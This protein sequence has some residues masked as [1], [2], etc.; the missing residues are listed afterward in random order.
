MN[1]RDAGSD[2]SAKIMHSAAQA[3]ANRPCATSAIRRGE[4]SRACRWCASAR[5]R[6]SRRP[7]APAAMQRRVD[8]AG[9]AEQPPAV[10]AL[11]DR[12]LETRAG[13]GNMKRARARTGRLPA[14]RG[15]RCGGRGRRRRA[16]RARS[17]PRRGRRGATMR[18]DAR[19]CARGSS[20][21]SREIG[22]EQAVA[23]QHDERLAASSGS[24]RLMPPPVSR[25]GSSGE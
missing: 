2:T 8:V 9:D 13:R 25:I 4:R 16:R 22:L 14:R 24:A 18:R 3:G 10:H 15:R 21:S 1:C 5:R 17:V 23:V 7:A 12:R 6:R 20:T 11:E 19:R